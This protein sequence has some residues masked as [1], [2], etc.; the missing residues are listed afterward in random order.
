MSIR[1]CDFC[2]DAAMYDGKTLLGPWAFMC[3]THFKEYG[4]PIKGL[5]TVLAPAATKVC[6][7][8]GK[9]KSIEEFYTYTDHNGKTRK[10]NECKE[11]N[12]AQKKQSSFRR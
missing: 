8:C 9:E 2:K 3:E 5:Y 4:F 7:V 12:L 11:C 6:R 10:R 1:K